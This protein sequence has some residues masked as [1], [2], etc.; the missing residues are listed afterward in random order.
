MAHT[1]VFLNEVIKYLNL[2][3]GSVIVD[4]TIG[5]GGHSMEIA[6][7]IAPNGVLIGIDQDESFLETL[8]SNFPWPGRQFPIST[9]SYTN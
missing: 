8:I 4:A 7:R 9:I 1:P 3:E 5:T 6:K 2:R